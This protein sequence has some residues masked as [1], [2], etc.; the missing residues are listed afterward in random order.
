[1]V[2]SNSTRLRWSRIRWSSSVS[3]AALGL[4]G[5]LG[6][7]RRLHD[8]RGDLE[9][10][11]PSRIGSFIDVSGTHVRNASADDA[12][13]V[14]AIGRKSMPAQYDGLVDS[15][16]VDAAV[17]QTYS[18]QAVAE[19][20]DRCVAAPDAQFLVAERSGEVVGFLHFDCFGPEPELHRLYLDTGH[21]GGGVGAQLMQVL[22][23]RL[24]S[25]T[26]YMLL[27]VEGNDR[28]VRFY[29]RHGLHVAEFVDGLAYYSDRMGVIFP[30]NACPF[31]LVLMRRRS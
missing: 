26:Q 17:S 3:C 30:A 28:A 18:R 5:L 31:R 12:A 19:C 23:E 6:R 16:A 1:M 2:S 21:R 20:I 24:G 4:G 13:V 25:G 15:A 7:S 22:H 27:V 10:Q 8:F 29:E 14:A 9:Q 11:D